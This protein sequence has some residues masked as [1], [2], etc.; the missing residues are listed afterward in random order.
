MNRFIWDLS[1]PGADVIPGSRLD[2]HIG[3]PRAV[4]GTYSARLELDDWSQTQN[5]NVLMDP[6]SESSVADLQAQFDLVQKSRDRISETHNAVRQIHAIRAEIDADEGR[7]AA[8]NESISPR[9]A[10]LIGAIRTELDDLEDQL[11][12][13]RATVWQDTANF[14]PL[15]DDQ[16]AWLASYTLSAES[17]PTDS[18][19]ER[20]ADLE[21]QLAVHI[22]RLDKVLR[23][24]V[25]SLR[26]LVQEQEERR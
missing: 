15:I 14:E 8:G 25:P 7:L 2:G 12:Q 3:G 10:E 4:P 21:Q 26:V 20:Y 9:L 5:F 1:Y 13:K 22:V 11:R 17:R 16:F 18:A 24:D 6:R 23:D 19:L